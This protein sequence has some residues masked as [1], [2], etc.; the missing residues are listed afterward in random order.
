[1]LFTREAVRDATGKLCLRYPRW[2]FR[3]M[4]ACVAVLLVGVMID[5]PREPVDV[6]AGVILLGGAVYMAI[7]TARYQLLVGEVS[8]RRVSPWPWEPAADIPLASVNRIEIRYQAFRATLVTGDDFELQVPF[9]LCG[10]FPFLDRVA[11][12][13]GAEMEERVRRY[14]DRYSRD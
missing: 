5:P 4:A 1:M 11:S 9:L 7:H 3:A 12:V 13:S 8:V 10:A 6:F 14:I 2:M